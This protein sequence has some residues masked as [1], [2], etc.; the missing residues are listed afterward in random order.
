MISSPV[1]DPG[2]GGGLVVHRPG[3]R[4]CLF[5]GGYTI[6][7]LLFLSCLS[8]DQQK[9]FVVVAGI[10]RSIDGNGEILTSN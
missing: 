2:L 10:G 3:S 1:D 8:M 6:P 4:F 9:K 7:R 5:G